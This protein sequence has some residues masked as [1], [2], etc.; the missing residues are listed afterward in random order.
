M[1]RRLG[2]PLVAAVSLSALLSTAAPVSAQTL[3]EA[4]SKAYQTNPQLLSQRARLRATDERL[5]QARAGW[6]PTVTASA[7]A[8]RSR[9]DIDGSPQAPF[10]LSPRQANVQINQPLYRG[11]RTVAGT[12]RA[13]QEIQAE[14]ARLFAV[15]Q[16]VLLN[17]ASAYLNVIRDRA[18]VDLNSSNQQV[19]Q[20]QLEATQDRFRVG[21]VT[22]TDVSQAEARLAGVVA[23]R[24]AAEGQ[25]QSSLANFEK[26]T[27]FSIN[28]PQRPSIPEALLPKTLDE[29]QSAAAEFNPSVVAARFDEGASR[30][31]VDEVRGEL[32][33]TV[34]LVGSIAYQEETSANS[35]PQNNAQILAQVQVP[36]YE[37]GAVYSRVR[38]AKQQANQRRIDIETTRR[39]AI[40]Q[41]TQAFQNLQSARARITSL[42]SQIRAAEIALDGV[43]QEATVGSRTVLD[44]LNAEQE[45]LNA[46]VSLVRSQRDEVV[47]AFTL[48]LSTG[49]LT[50]QR[51]TLPVEIYDFESNFRDVENRWLG[52]GIQGE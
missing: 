33:P 29:A 4:L 25:L 15:E 48:L 12:E 2:L 9:L 49:R 31:S 22:R 44:V 8:G 41:A 36:I 51:L 46:R 39:N 1:L 43:R 38:A 20:T 16:E 42:T 52:T 11:G 34:S 6:R 50:A 47:A 17:T 18:T 40:E 35:R 13:K 21:E 19:L 26:L 24:I 3:E 32:L 10:E 5:P 45:L 30:N 28:S 7:S 27:G 37:A 23:D 14:R